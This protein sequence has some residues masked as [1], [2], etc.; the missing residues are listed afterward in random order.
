[1]KVSYH[2]D[3][4]AANRV[5]CA[6]DRSGFQ[7]AFRDLLI[8]DLREL[9]E[10]AR[11]LDVG[12]GGDIPRGLA[13]IQPY[14]RRCDGVDPDPDVERHPGLVNRFHGTLEEAPLQTS[15][16]DLAFAYNVIEHVDDPAGFLRKLHDVLKPG[17]VFWAL[18]PHANHPFC[19]LSRSIELLG[20]KKTAADRLEA[21]EGKRIVN[22]YP[23]YYRLNRAG[24]IARQAEACQFAEADFYYF[25]CRQWDRYFPSITRIAPWLYDATVGMRFRACMLLLAFRLRK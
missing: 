20:F 19:L 23:A 25:P 1:M 16:Y 14:L 22:D 15:A 6:E 2:P 18:T 9:P 3:V 24:A 10:N 17:A 4:D 21:A 8:G 7:T 12:C 5:A 11:V 13:P